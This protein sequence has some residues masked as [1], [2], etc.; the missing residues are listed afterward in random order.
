MSTVLVPTSRRL[1]GVA[2]GSAELLGYIRAR[3]WNAKMRLQCITASAHVDVEA[4]TQ[5]REQGKRRR[6]VVESSRSI[7]SLL[8]LPNWCWGS[9]LEADHVPRRAVR[10]RH[11]QRLRELHSTTRPK[12]ALRV[13]HTDCPERLAKVFSG[14]ERDFR[15]MRSCTR[16]VLCISVALNLPKRP[17]AV[18][19]TALPLLPIDLALVLVQ[20]ARQKVRAPLLHLFQ[21]L[22]RDSSLRLVL[23]RGRRCRRRCFSL[24]LPGGC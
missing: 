12:K 1:N 8:P 15:F 11:G 17:V 7:V 19:G 5:D 4:V 16:H 14:S 9:V 24:R 22:R 21:E 20:V 23:R 2:S 6:T 18:H 3:D 13:H 10:Q